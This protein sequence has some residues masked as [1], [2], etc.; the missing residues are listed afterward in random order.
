M[1]T[2]NMED[3]LLDA[4]LD[5]V[6][7][8]WLADSFHDLDP[9][10]E[11]Y[12]KLRAKAHEKLG[13]ALVYFRTGLNTLTLEPT[14]DDAPY[15]IVLYEPNGKRKFWNDN[16]QEGWTFLDRATEYNDVGLVSALAGRL[17]ITHAT[18]GHVGFLTLEQAK[19][20]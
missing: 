7:R 16:G 15:V 19:G 14:D 3:L 17:G 20:L 12:K 5:A 18:L 11:Q 1:S 13:E 10:D 8:G 4:M 2:H 6:A 9:N